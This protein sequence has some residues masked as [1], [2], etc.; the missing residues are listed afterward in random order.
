MKQKNCEQQVGYGCPPKEHRFQ[1]GRSGNPSG[2]PK[3]RQNFA[4][5]LRDELAELISIR[6]DN[7]AVEVTK[8]R[9]IIK[10]LL[11]MAIAGD[12]RAI[13]TIV[14]SCVRGLAQDDRDETEAPE[15]SAIMAA[16]AITPR[17]NRGRSS[18]DAPAAEEQ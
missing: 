1:P 16:V 4:S 10:T 13:A 9:A 14:G 18:A 15:D 6:D 5:D 3:G 12:P 2:R 17:K 7:K 8:Q 11:R